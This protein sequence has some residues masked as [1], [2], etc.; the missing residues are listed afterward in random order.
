MQ[1]CSMYASSC[2]CAVARMCACFSTCFSVLV[3][4]CADVNV[5]TCIRFRLFASE[6]VLSSG[7]FSAP[8][9]E[10]H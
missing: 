3:R 8:L 2:M 10:A 4:M 5:Y 9:H 6:C 7:F 1:V